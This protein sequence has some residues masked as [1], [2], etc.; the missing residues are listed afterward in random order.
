[1]QFTLSYNHFSEWENMSHIIFLFQVCIDAVSGIMV[2][3]FF[4]FAGRNDEIKKV[5]NNLKGFLSLKKRKATKPKL[6]TDQIPC[7]SVVSPDADQ[8]I[9]LLLQQ[10]TGDTA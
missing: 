10:G 4:M 9:V 2:P 3:P 8:V 6:A 7:V 1:V 5:R